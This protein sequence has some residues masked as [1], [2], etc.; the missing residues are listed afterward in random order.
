MPESKESRTMT[1]D[2]DIHKEVARLIGN[3]FY[4][5]GHPFRSGRTGMRDFARLSLLLPAVPEAE[6]SRCVAEVERLAGVVRDCVSCSG[7]LFAFLSVLCA[8]RAPDKARHYA[9]RLRRI[10]RQ[11]RHGPGDFLGEVMQEIRCAKADASD[12]EEG[13]EEDVHF[14][15]C[16]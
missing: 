16:P 4:E 11:V 1:D 9:E 8:E 14:G 10:E 13:G 7:R 15:V 2:A 6:F 3:R 5:H 12:K